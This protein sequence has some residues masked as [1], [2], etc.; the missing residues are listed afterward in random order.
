M[1]Y[2]KL[3][4]RNYYELVELLRL[5]RIALKVS[6]LELDEIAGF[7]TAYTGKLEKPQST[8]GR[9]ARW[10]TLEWWLGA[11]NVGLMLVPLPRRSASNQNKTGSCHHLQ[12]ELPLNTPQKRGDNHPGKQ[13]D[14]NIN[15]AESTVR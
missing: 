6:Q 12:L 9:H 15:T 8:Y 14:S 3:T 2:H 4:A 5:R 11:L 13:C 10:D 7:Q 1:N